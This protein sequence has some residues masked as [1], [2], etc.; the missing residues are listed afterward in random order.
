VQA[1]R[2]PDYIA[3]NRREDWGITPPGVPVSTKAPGEP[4]TCLPFG[5]FKLLAVRRGIG[6]PNVG[7]PTEHLLR[8]NT[9]LRR[10][11]L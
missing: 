6:M 5:P 8:N 1:P 4:Q 7:Q 3:Y 2:L 11:T 9:G 10:T